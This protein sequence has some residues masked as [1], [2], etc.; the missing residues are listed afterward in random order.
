MCKTF[1]ASAAEG[2]VDDAGGETAVLVAAPLLGTLLLGIALQEYIQA[3]SATSTSTALSGSTTPGGGGYDPQYLPA[4]AR[5]RS[6]GEKSEL[7]TCSP[8]ASDT[9]AML[10]MLSAAAAANGGQGARQMRSIH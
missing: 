10:G 7:T 2:A 1:T 4:F 3:S 6:P 5:R 9:T 8:H